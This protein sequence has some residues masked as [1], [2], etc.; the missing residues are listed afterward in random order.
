MA[1]QRVDCTT[2]TSTRS[3]LWLSSQK[4]RV[5]SLVEEE[6]ERE[7][8]QWMLLLQK[9]GLNNVT[10]TP[11]NRPLRVHFPRETMRA[12]ERLKKASKGEWDSE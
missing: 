9:S 2:S 11:I 12:H 5:A 4:E 7:R 6:W 3:T 1:F 10:K 8:E